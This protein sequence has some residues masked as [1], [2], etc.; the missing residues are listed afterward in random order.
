ML[1]LN[2]C[3]GMSGWRQ[4]DMRMASV[5]QLSA[6]HAAH[7]A[8]LLGPRASTTKVTAEGCPCVHSSMSYQAAAKYSTKAPSTNVPG[9]CKHCNKLVWRFHILQYWDNCKLDEGDWVLC[10]RRSTRLQP[11]SSSS[12]SS[13]CSGQVTCRHSCKIALAHR[14][15][16]Q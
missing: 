7:L 15:Q 13:S 6:M 11:R 10:I 5:V 8:W 3:W 16:Q 2:C 12:S 1:L 4:G 9:H 14:Q